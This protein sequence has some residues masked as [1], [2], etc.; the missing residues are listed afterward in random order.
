V[1]TSRRA[2]RS[3][4]AQ[5]KDAFHAAAGCFAVLVKEKSAGVRI[6]AAVAI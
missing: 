2:T 1:L 5:N 3:G 6:S 4:A